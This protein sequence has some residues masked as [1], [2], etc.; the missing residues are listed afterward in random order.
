MITHNLKDDYPDFFENFSNYMSLNYFSII[1]IGKAKAGKST[2]LNY[3]HD[4]NSYLE[5]DANI[6]TK[7]ICIIR[8]K[9]NN[10]K[11]KIFNVIAEK[12][13]DGK[14]FNFIKGKEIKGEISKVISERNKKIAKKELN[15]DPLN[16]FL[17]IEANLPIFNGT[18]LEKYSDFFEIYGCS[19]IK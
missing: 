19:W 16:Y 7:F 18:C 9:R 5:I 12:R 10:K 4:F 3:I 15:L 11:P 1:I 13:G 6:A 14:N 17:L 2:F 8:H